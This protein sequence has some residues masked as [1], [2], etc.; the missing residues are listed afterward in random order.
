MKE[1]DK[2][3]YAVLFIL[4]VVTVILTLSLASIYKNRE[5]LTSEFYNYSNAITAKEFDEY[6]LESPD[7]IIYLADKYD[8]SFNKFESDFQAKLEDMNLKNKLVYIDKA[9][10]TK[11][12]LK[13]FKN[14]YQINIYKKNL[15]IIIIMVDK[16]VIKTININSNSNVDSIIDFKVFE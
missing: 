16:K 9:N 5:K 13:E 8:R 6:A 4:L 15:P 3:N 11:D 14:D 2:K 1:I 12:L 10:I 7:L